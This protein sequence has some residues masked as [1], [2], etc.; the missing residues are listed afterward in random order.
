[1]PRRTDTLD[2]NSFMKDSSEHRLNR[3]RQKGG[4]RVNSNLEINARVVS[5]ALQ[6][7]IEEG[8]IRIPRGGYI[9]R[10]GRSRVIVERSE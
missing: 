7:L 1:M 4:Q 10:R 9:V 2:Q 6:P 5:S 3:G 8:K